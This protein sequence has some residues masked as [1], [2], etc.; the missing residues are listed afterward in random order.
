MHGRWKKQVTV[1]AAIALLAACGR[2]DS[3]PAANNHGFGFQFD[4]SGVTGLRVRY[5]DDTSPR[6][7]FIEQMYRETMECVGFD[8][9]G[10]LVIWLPSVQSD[11]GENTFGWIFLDTGTILADNNACILDNC[12]VLAFQGH[13]L[14]H[15][16][17]HWLLHRSGRLTEAQQHA[18]AAVEFTS[19]TDVSLN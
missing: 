14:K 2:G 10:P 3:D 17:V 12:K 5:L 9:P 1:I 19:C 18:H 13:V 6:L 16:F 8:A 15:Q 11:D 4:E 7:D